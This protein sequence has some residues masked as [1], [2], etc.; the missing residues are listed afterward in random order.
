MDKTTASG[1]VHCDTGE[2][3]TVSRNFGSLSRQSN[4]E[5]KQFCENNITLAN[6][7][8]GVSGDHFMFAANTIAASFLNS[9]I[10]SSF[11]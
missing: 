1:T 4:K 3:G 7:W 10:H 2:V 5:Y 11:S 9:F 8:L 6:N